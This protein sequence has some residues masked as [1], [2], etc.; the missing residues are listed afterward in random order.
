MKKINKKISL[1]IL[2]INSWALA[3]STIPCVC[4]DC[5]CEI[6]IH[7]GS[8]DK[9]A[10]LQ[11]YLGENDVYNYRSNDLCKNV[12]VWKT[13][14]EPFTENSMILSSEGKRSSQPEFTIEVKGK[15]GKLIIKN[16]EYCIECDWRR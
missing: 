5:E 15:K 7:V 8:D 6:H 4:L 9:A 10:D 13:T 14:E 12:I 11:I 2:L 16:K 1:V 3:T